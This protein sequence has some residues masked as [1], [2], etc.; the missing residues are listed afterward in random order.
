MGK[1]ITVYL[2]DKELEVLESLLE[3]HD[4]NSMSRILKTAL[5]EMFTRDGMMLKEDLPH[6]KAP[7][8]FT[9]GT[10]DVVRKQIAKDVKKD[11]KKAGGLKKYIEKIGGA[12]E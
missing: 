12:E 7:I 4:T 2:T 1:K 6:E 5:I 10:M 9:K 8:V 11:I 3:R